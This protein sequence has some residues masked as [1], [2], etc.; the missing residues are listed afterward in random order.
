MKRLLFS[1][2]IFVGLSIEAYAQGGGGGQQQTQQTNEPAAPS[3]PVN[4]Y[5]EYNYEKKDVKERK[6]IP[7]PPLREADVFY[8]KRVERVIDTHEKK[9]QV[10]VWPKSA[11][12]KIVFNLV[13]NG[14]PNSTGK[15]KAYRSDTL[16]NAFTIDR[17]ASCRERV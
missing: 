6:A 15:L 1:L 10:M 17:R 16:D 4:K 12:Y 2:V 9:N 13:L 11:L 5:L 7:Y 14:E 8:A 3:K